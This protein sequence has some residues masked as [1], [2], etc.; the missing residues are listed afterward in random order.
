VDV[1]SWDKD[2]EGQLMFAVVL[3]FLVLRYNLAVFDERARDGRP[4]FHVE[5]AD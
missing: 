3:A 5:E 4:H 1:R 2:R